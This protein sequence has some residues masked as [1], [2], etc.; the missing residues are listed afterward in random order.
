TIRLNDFHTTHAVM[1]PEGPE[2]GAPVAV[3]IRLLS[4]PDEDAAAAAIP[5]AFGSL[6]R[7]EGEVPDGAQAITINDHSVI[8][9]AGLDPSRGVQSGEWGASDVPFSRLIA[10]QGAMVVTVKVSSADTL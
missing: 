7:Q 10:R 5:A 9:V 1:I 2:G 4:F 3:E 6:L 8:A